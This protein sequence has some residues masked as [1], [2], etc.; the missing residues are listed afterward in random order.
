MRFFAVLVLVLL[1]SGCAALRGPVERHGP[2]LTVYNER[3][4]PVD[5]SYRCVEHGAVHRIGV[6][7]PRETQRFTLQPAN[8][9]SLHLIQHTE[10]HRQPVE[11]VVPLFGE[12]TLHLTLALWGVERRVSSP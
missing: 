10:G 7:L 1:A 11:D 12:R 6:V 9:G 5:L 2:V 4:L 3:D 8:C